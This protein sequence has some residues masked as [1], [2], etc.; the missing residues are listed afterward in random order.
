[1]YISICAHVDLQRT[2]LRV[3]QDSQPRFSENLMCYGN[4]AQPAFRKQS[5]TTSYAVPVILRFPELL[6][7]RRL[8][9]QRVICTGAARTFF[10]RH[11]HLQKV[12]GSCN[13]LEKHIYNC[14]D[15]LQISRIVLNSLSDVL[16]SDQHVVYFGCDAWFFTQMS[17]DSAVLFSRFL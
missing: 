17:E 3:T 1:M 16:D 15:L 10:L 13:S 2:S 6:T 5:L 14:R 11:S 8:C 12:F 7:V 4:T 9:I